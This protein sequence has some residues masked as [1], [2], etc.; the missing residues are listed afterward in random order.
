[1][2]VLL[3]TGPLGRV[4]HPAPV[5][6][7]AECQQWLQQI[8]QLGIAVRVPEIADYE[9]RRELLRANLAE[10]IQRLDQLGAALGYVPITTPTMKRAAE[11]WAAARR[12]GR[13]TA[14]NKALDVDIILTAQQEAVRADDPETVIATENVG[15]L[16]LFADARHWRDIS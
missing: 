14:D 7:N 4:V 9:L 5:R 3:D 13:P 11:L 16:N 10:A 12:Q 8:L 2:I 1:M 15:H 6:V